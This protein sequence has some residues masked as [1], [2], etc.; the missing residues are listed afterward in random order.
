[1]LFLLPFAPWGVAFASDEASAPPEP[2]PRIDALEHEVR[3]L[4][5]RLDEAQT[6]ALMR[7]AEALAAANAPPP[8]PPTRAPNVFNPQITAFG[9]LLGTWGFEDAELDPASGL[10]LRSLELDLQA[11]VDPFARAV[12]VMAMEQEPPVGGAHADEEAEGQADTPGAADSDEEADSHAAFAVV[13]EEVYIDL[14]SLPGG[15][16]GRV[17]AFKQPFG[18]ANRAHPHDYPWS[19]AP[20][21]IQAALGEDGWSDVGATLSWNRALGPTAVTLTGGV[22]DGAGHLDPLRETPMPQWLG[23]AELFVDLGA[24]DLGLGSSHT[25]LEADYL[26][27]A[28]MMLRWRG[29]SWRSVVL[30]GEGFL[31]DEGELSGYAALQVQP[32]RTLYAGAR[33]DSVHEELQAGG[34]LSYYTSEFLRLRA[35]AV[36]GEHGV[37]VHSQ[38]TFVWG[39]HPVEPY[40]VNR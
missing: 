25:G 32:T 26:G 22:L 21:P 23:R 9:D 8:P 11:D 14:V 20:A 33:V 28:D 6:E 29:S 34:F 19:D 5:E 4:T 3:T 7:E 24:V 35:G 10:W 2:D 12:A 16:S 30:L 17:G 18:I 13:P 36:A 39:S 38:L 40:W 15:F 27:G 31:D 1:M 37:T